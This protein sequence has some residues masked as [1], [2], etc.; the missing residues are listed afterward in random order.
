MTVAYGKHDR[1]QRGRPA[2]D[3]ILDRE[4]II[5]PWGIRDAV[6]AVGLVAVVAVAVLAALG[7]LARG[8]DTV[9]PTLITVALIVPQSAMF[10]AAWFFGVRKYRTGWRSLGF[11]GPA[12]LSAMLLPGPVLLASIAASAL[13]VVIVSALKLDALTPPDVARDLLGVGVHRLANA[14]VIGLAGPL[15][16]ETFFRGF[17][18]A[19][20]IQPL[21]PVRAAIVASAVFSVGHV[22]I[23]AMIPLFITGLLLSWLY[24]KTGSVWP[25]FTAHAAQ[26]ILALAATIAALE[27][28]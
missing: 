4:T 28:A 20:L 23:G 5:V 13:Y 19:A 26:N 8:H 15:I 7:L 10:A 12:Q 11:I 6:L 27:G 17:L 16:E 9:S 25:P 24:L 21:G 14:V 18:L 22:S 3:S 1:P 2:I